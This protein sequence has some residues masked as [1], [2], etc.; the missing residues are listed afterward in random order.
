VTRTAARHTYLKEEV[1]ACK[2]TERDTDNGG[3]DAE[4]CGLDSFTHK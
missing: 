4:P 2:E 1:T 3:T